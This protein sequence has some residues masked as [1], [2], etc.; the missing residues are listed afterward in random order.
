[1]TARPLFLVSL[2]LISAGAI[3]EPA[4]R[5]QGSVLDLH[6]APLTKASGVDPFTVYYPTYPG[7]IGGVT[8]SGLHGISLWNNV[9]GAAFTQAAPGQTGSHWQLIAVPDS[10]RPAASFDQLFVLKLR[11]GR[12]IHFSDFKVSEVPKIY[13]LTANPKSLRLAERVPGKAWSLSLVDKPTGL[14]IRFEL[15][16]RD[17]AN[18]F[19]SILS[20]TPTKQPVDIATVT[21]LDGALKGARVVGTTSGS[22]V[23]GEGSYAGMEHP[24]SLNTAS[25]GKFTS[26]VLRKLPLEPDQTTTYSAVVGTFAPGEMRRGFLRY[27]EGERARPYAPF[28]HY[29]SWYDLG[30]FSKYTAEECKQVIKTYGEKLVRLRG[31]KMASFLFDDGWDDTSTV[32]GFNS[33]FPKGF[34]EVADVAKQYN[35]A[36]GAWL[37]PWGGYG[38][39][40]Q[41]RLATAAKLGYEFDSQ[42]YAL[43][44]PKYYERFRQVCLDLVQNQGINQFKLDGT[45]SPDKKY[46]GSKFGSDFEAAIALIDDLRKA[47][48]S[49]F[50][51]LTTGTWPSPFWTKTA[52]SIWRG[53]EDHSFAGVGTKRQQWITYKD[54][55]TYRGIVQQGPLYPLNSLM[56]HGIIYAKHAHDLNTDPGDDFRREVMAYFGTGTQLQEMYVSPE[57]LTDDNWDALAVAA[58]WTNAN[59]QTLVDTHWIGGDPN[60]LEVYGHAAWNGK[61][62][63]IVLRN[64]SN[65]PQ[66]YSLEPIRALELPP[67]TKGHL[68]MRDVYLDSEEPPVEMDVR[69]S[70]VIKLRPF[71]VL[72]LQGSIAAAKSRNGDRK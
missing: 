5:S 9:F 55:D 68:S 15:Q 69:G 33:G 28:L 57:L 21:L 48:P 59:A 71:E 1:M 13:G 30:Y 45:G 42:G 14:K 39:P 20:L 46:P 10:S 62:A 16:M 54:G 23:V 34:R 6:R 3:A 47:K 2:V 44:G 7:K 31:A 60:K 8:L 43:S 52:D 25:G 49:L 41:Q 63:I 4:H 11:D 36:P 67:T 50:I 17:Q 64:P 26:S 58:R 53:G 66:A 61:T 29:N 18:W 35:S 24:M 32:W 72:T 70:K 38:P 56:L 27:V 65:M 40:R 22:P 19:R 51:N 37:S 12:A